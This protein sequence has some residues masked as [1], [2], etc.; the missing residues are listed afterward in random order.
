MVWPVCPIAVAVGGS[1]AAKQLGLKYCPDFRPFLGSQV[2]K[3]MIARPWLVPNQVF[4]EMLFVKFPATT[5]ALGLAVLLL[6]CATDVV[7][8][9]MAKDVLVI[10]PFASWNC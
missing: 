1:G 2:R 4:E 6:S 10:F 8:I 3:G 9:G 7:G 5:I